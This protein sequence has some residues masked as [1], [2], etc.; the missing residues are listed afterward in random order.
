MFF[1]MC[2]SVP[3]EVIE[4]KEEGVVLEYPGEVREIEVSLVD[5]VVGDFCIVSGGVVV[6]KV[7]RE[8]AKKFLEMIDGS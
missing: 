2:L 6:S 3:G 7:E 4:L 1:V 5:L 8:R